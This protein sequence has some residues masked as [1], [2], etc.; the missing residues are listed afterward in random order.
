MFMQTARTNYGYYDRPFKF[1]RRNSNNTQQKSSNQDEKEILCGSVFKNLPSGRFDATGGRTFQNFRRNNIYQDEIHSESQHEQTL[2]HQESSKSNNNNTIEY[3]L[4]QGS[5]QSKQQSVHIINQVLETLESRFNED[6][7]TVNN[8]SSQRIQDLNK[9][10]GKRSL[11]INSPSKK[12]IDAYRTKI[13]MS[14]EKSGQKYLHSEL[15]DFSQNLESNPMYSSKNILRVNEQQNLHQIYLAA[16]AAKKKE[17]QDNYH[18]QVLDESILQRSNLLMTRNIDQSRIKSVV[19]QRLSKED[20]LRL[21]KEK[22]SQTKVQLQGTDGFQQ[23]HKSI[24]KCMKISKFDSA[25]CL[26]NLRIEKNS[27]QQKDRTN[28]HSVNRQD[29]SK[30]QIELP[31]L[32]QAS[33][34]KISLFNS[35]KKLMNGQ[36]RIAHL[37]SLL[38]DTFDSQGSGCRIRSESKLRDFKR[39]IDDE[40]DFQK[41]IRNT[42][43]EKFNVSKKD[44]SASKSKMMKTD[45]QPLLAESQILRRNNKSKSTF[46]TLIIQQLLNEE[47]KLFN[48]ISVNLLTETDSYR[49]QTTS[50]KDSNGSNLFSNQ[51]KPFGGS[52]RKNQSITQKMNFQDYMTQILV[53]ERLNDQTFQ[54]T[55]KITDKH[56]KKASRDLHRILMDQFIYPT[57]NT[58]LM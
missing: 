51:N 53:E 7:D 43:F 49:T 40:Y 21:I 2:S 48:P 23:Y 36:Q 46:Q 11:L 4:S 44:F 56:F 15:Y 10:G 20:I 55:D 22:I 31:K 1:G 28:S 30:V 39:Q 35:Q 52:A 8:G 6:L 12:S 14:P 24:S 13:S 58:S 5:K 19:V 50:L 54:R 47:Q 27:Q 16:K 41:A 42:N 9:Q 17:A 32:I 18:K 3:R 26:N 38:N 34:N 29:M 25:G 45:Y 33:K 57:Q 37:K